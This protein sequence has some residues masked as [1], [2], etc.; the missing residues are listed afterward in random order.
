MRH[1]N[2][3]RKLGVKTAHRTALLRNLVRG[4]VINKRIQTTVAKAREASAFSDNMVELAK[5][6]TLHSRRLLISRLGSEE[7]ADILIKDIAPQFQD[8][9]GG[10]TRV[11]RLADVRHGDAAPKAILEF[12]AP[13]ETT[14]EKIEK[15]RAARLKKKNAKKD[16]A[17]KAAKA[18]KG[19]A[20]TETKK[21]KAKKKQDKAE[22]AQ[23]PAKEA[24][25]TPEEEKKESDKKGG[26]I[27][28]L[29]KFLK[30]DE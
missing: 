20:E 3:R 19:T 5:K 9:K 2:L 12:T 1:R 14:A 18:E 24:P 7:M 11:L 23:E 17:E 27:G 4:L 30:G 22:K 10:Y 21:P 26:F 6:N 13:F 29:R 8:R 15:A 28:K 16:K 25:S